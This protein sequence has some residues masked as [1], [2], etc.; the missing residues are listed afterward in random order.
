MSEIRIFLNI[1][2]CVFLREN[3]HKNENNS[4]GNWLGTSHKMLPELEKASSSTLTNLSGNFAGDSME[5]PDLNP[6]LTP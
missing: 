2:N 5:N 6:L 1:E 4:A 3:E